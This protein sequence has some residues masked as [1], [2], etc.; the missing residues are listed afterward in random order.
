MI[1]NEIHEALCLVDKSHVGETY[2]ASEHEL[3]AVVDM[4]WADVLRRSEL[5][6]IVR[7][8]VVAFFE[9]EK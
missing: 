7:R 5:K 2:P 1:R 8:E 9:K 4:I 6:E 3:A